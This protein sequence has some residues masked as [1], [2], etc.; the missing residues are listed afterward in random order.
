MNKMSKRYYNK[1]K[2][3]E[4][5]MTDEQIKAVMDLYKPN[6]VQKLLMKYFSPLETTNIY[7]NTAVGVALGLFG[8]GI[9][10]NVTAEIIV[11]A[12]WIALFLAGGIYDRITN[13]KR[14]T[15]L[16][17]V[18]SMTKEQVIELEKKYYTA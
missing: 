2:K 9:I 6:F 5:V 14:I 11:A 15:Q 18:L 1:K 4:A 8:V 3:M 12:S 7:R 13:Q 10:F 17:S 16:M